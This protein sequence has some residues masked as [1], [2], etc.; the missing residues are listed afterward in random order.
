VT[1]AAIAAAASKTLGR[2]VAAA[3]ARSVLE[4]DPFVY[5]A[6][7]REDREAAS[8]VLGIATGRLS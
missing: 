2:E 8:T 4:G 5:D 3:F 1:C 7:C 6:A